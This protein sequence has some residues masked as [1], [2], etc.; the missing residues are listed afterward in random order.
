MIQALFLGRNPKPH[1]N[2]HCSQR[3]TS[4]GQ[5]L[6]PRSHAHSQNRILL[7]HQRDLFH[8]HHPTDYPQ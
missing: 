3:S 4:P 6:I 8:L 7:D 5:S 1:S 2:S